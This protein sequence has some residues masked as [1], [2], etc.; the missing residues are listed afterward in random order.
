MTTNEKI[1]FGFAFFLAQRPQRS[2]QSRSWLT[3]EG[4]LVSRLG[5]FAEIARV[6]RWLRGGLGAE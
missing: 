5:C 4:D 2:W 3:G 1:I 6:Y